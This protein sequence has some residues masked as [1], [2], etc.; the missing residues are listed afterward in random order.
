MTA[1]DGMD[2]LL[3]AG[4]MPEFEQARQWVERSLDVA[5]DKDINLFETTIRILGGLMSV[6]HL[7]GG[8]PTDPLLAKA[9]DLARADPPAPRR[10]PQRATSPDTAAAVVMQ[11]ER[12]MP[13]FATPT[14]I[15]LSDVN[16]K[17][18]TAKGPEWS[19]SSRYAASF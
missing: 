16:P 10:L 1:V 8:G 3:L 17:H 9:V 6:H 19:R 18:R 14:G 15:P 12:M 4:L 5:V 7:S 2:T 11:A 13:A